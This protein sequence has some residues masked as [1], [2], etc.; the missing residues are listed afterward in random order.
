[1]RRPIAPLAASLL[2]LGLGAAAHAESAVRLPLPREFGEIEATTYDDA[3][4]ERLGP[5][6]MSMKRLPSGDIEMKAQTGIE[7]SARTGVSAVLERTLGGNALRLV[8]QH[9]ES[10]DESGHSLGILSIDHHQGTATCGAPPASKKRATYV[11]LPKEDRVVN[12]PLNLLFDPLVSGEQSEVA[13]QVLLCRF[14]ARLIDAR[15]RVAG[16]DGGLIEVR[17]NMDFGMF[18]SLASPFLPRLSFWFDA[19]APS[20]WVGHRMPLFS[21]GPTVLVVR[22]GF[23]PTQLEGASAT[24]GGGH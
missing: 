11:E 15:A 24:G 2:L 1:M 22:S 13:F 21:K 14:G 17:Y 20:A 4:L 18:S 16:D 5:A 8:S 23:A 10:F 9:S 12:V 3:S 19:E 7:G 6:L